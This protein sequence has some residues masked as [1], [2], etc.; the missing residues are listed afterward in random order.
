MFSFEL[1]QLETIDVRPA[2]TQV[3]SFRCGC[4]QQTR[5]ADYLGDFVFGLLSNFSGQAKRVSASERG[6]R[7]ACKGSNRVI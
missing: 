1:E 6:R 3:L 7:L 5:P 2:P 4:S